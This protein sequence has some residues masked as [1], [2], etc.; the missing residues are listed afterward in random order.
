MNNE[1]NQILGVVGMSLLLFFIGSMTIISAGCQKSS[2]ESSPP[3]TK[4]LFSSWTNTEDSLDVLDLTDAKIGTALYYIITF[5][6]G[7][8][9]RWDLMILGN[10]AVG[11]YSLTNGI[12]ILGPA[13]TGCSA[14]TENGSYR[15]EG[16][17][18]SICEGGTD[19][20]TYQ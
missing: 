6:D 3:A 11:V 14:L 19:C 9:C 10:E 4:S 12:H 1:S 13:D 15:L 20:D 2:S 5:L 7:N 17:T 18:L 8:A 16:N